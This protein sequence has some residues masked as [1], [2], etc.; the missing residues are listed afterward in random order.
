MS[1]QITIEEALIYVMIMTSASDSAMSD[2]ELARIGRLTRFLP[3]FEDFDDERLIEVSRDCTAIVNGPEGLDVLLEVIKDTLP[4]RLYDTAY[5][6]G[7]EVATAD[8]VLKT[9][10]IRI[11]QLLRARLGIEK[12]TAA[13]IERGAIAR[14][15]KI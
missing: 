5:A 1:K 14:F 8:M 4:E 7:V 12:L 2:E 9:E 3:V 10:E 13:A 15:K 11:L 6:L